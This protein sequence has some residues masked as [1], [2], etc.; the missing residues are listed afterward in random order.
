MPQNPSVKKKTKVAK[1][2]L[3]IEI[4]EIFKPL[5][6]EK[7]RIKFYYGGRG[8]GK[9][10]AFADSLLLLARQKKLFIACLRE[11]QDSI[12][13]S[14]YKLLCDRISAWGLNDY[15][16]Y[17]SRIENLHTGSKFIFRGLRDQDVNNIKSLEGVDIAWIEEAHTITKKS[18][19]ILSP[20]IRKNGSD[21]WISMNREEENDPLWV[22]L[23]AKPDD[24]TLV[25]KVNYYD[26]PFCPEEIKLQAEQCKITNPDD[27]EHIWLGEPVRQ[28]NYKLISSQKVRNAIVPKID[29]STSPLIIGLDIARFGDDQTSFCFRK[30]RWCMRFETYKKLDN[31]AVA[32]LATN[33]IRTMQPKRIFM[34]IGGQGAGVYDIL[35]DR[36]FA[37]I[38]RGVY[39]GEKALNEG[40]YFNRRAEM[41]DAIRDWLDDKLPVQL[42]NDEELFDD[43]TSVNKK[44]DRKGRLCLEEKDELK[45]RL[46]RSPDK[47]DALALTFAEPVYDDGIPRLY[48]N[49][50]I[51]FEDLFNKPKR[52]TEW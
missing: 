47:G 5:L 12:K 6:S 23:A 15:K 22:L 39:F 46:G 11:I 43:L 48:G 33:I 28:G 25:R 34:D 41:W 49:G 16:I 17:E 24:R 44:Y 52:S 14:V 9:S 30:G 7:W 27:Y 26:N 32:N 8:G 21:I 42:P 37:E 50:Q 3:K 10:Y 18:W 19:N 31:V 45:K 40:R 35:K 2:E 1:A 51:T 13:D 29:S 4:A 38:I 36:G 20:T